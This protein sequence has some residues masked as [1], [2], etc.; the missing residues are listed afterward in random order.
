MSANSDNKPPA[1]VLPCLSEPG[2]LMASSDEELS[3]ASYWDGRYSQA[4]GTAPT[5]ERFRSYDALEDF[6]LVNLFNTAGLTASDNPLILHLGSGDSVCCVVGF[7]KIVPD[8]AN[9]L[10]RLLVTLRPS[11]TS[12]PPKATSGRYALTSLRRR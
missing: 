2:L 3:K 11:P 8:K 10:I 1:L 4:D 5:H 12:L 7:D 9:P 6:F